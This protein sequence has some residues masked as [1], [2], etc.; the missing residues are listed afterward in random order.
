M[1]GVVGIFTKSSTDAVELCASLLFRLQH[2]G[3]DGAGLVSYAGEG[4]YQ[5]VKG[6]GLISDALQ[7]WTTLK[8]SK[9]ALG[10]TRYATTGTGGIVELQPFVSGLPKI[11]MAHNGNISNVH[12]V[13]ER[14]VGTLHTESDLELLQEEFLKTYASTGF[15]SAVQHLMDVFEGGYAVV[16]ILDN[17]DLYGFRDPF[18]IRPLFLAESSDVVAMASET[19]P[20]DV[21]GDVTITEIKPGEWVRYSDGK[22]TRGLTVSKKNPESKRRSCMFESVYFSSPQSSIQ[23]TSVYRQRFQLGR[24]LAKQISADWASTTFLTDE[25]DFVVPVPETSRIAATAVA[26]EL[27]IPFREFLIK[28]PYVPRTFILSSQE[29]RLQALSQKLSL[30]GPELKGKRILLVDDSVVRG[31]TSRLMTQRLRE[32]GAKAVYLASTCPPIVSG[33][34]YGIDFPDRS[35]LIAADQSIDQVSKLIGVDGLFYLNLAG[36]KKALATENLCTGCL[37]GEYPYSDA[38]HGRFV[39]E[40]RKQR[41][42]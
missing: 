1:C 17:G 26:E 40:R 24:Y 33:C 15:I 8:P 7:E 2:R 5:V 18:G 35:E 31:N 14:F 6:R 22:L 32:A 16:G 19:G 23:D 27:G 29:K 9:S 34:Y 25:I 42:L 21:L 4:Q 11:A 20:L 12:E 37:T 39:E 13:R 3:Q 38:H 28:N 10:H 41:C 30:V 36:L